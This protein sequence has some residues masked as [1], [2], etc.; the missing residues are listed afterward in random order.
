MRRHGDEIFDGVIPVAADRQR[1]EVLVVDQNGEVTMILRQSDRGIEIARFVEDLIEFSTFRQINGSFKYKP[2]RH[3][4]VITR[5]CQFRSHSLKKVRSGSSD[6][7]ASKF[8][9]TDLNLVN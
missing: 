3:S 1:H 6:L 2:D 5:Q 9:L 7:N 4:S 8:P